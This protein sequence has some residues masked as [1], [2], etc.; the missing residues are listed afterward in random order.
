MIE[1][2]WALPLTLALVGLPAADSQDKDKKRPEAARPA[3]T[4]AEDLLRQAD[5]KAAAGDGAGAVALLRKAQ[6]LPGAPAE[7]GLRLGR[8]LEAARDLDGA[9]D[10]YRE[11]AGK[12]A[13]PAKGEALGRLALVQEVRGLGGAAESAQ[14]AAS[15]DPEGAWPLLALARARAREG[16]GEEAAALAQKAAGKEAGPPAQAA[17]GAAEEARG[18]WA[19]AEAAYRAAGG[20]AS[21]DIAATTGLARVLRRTGRAAEAAPLLEPLIAAYPGAVYAL[22]ESARVKIALGR[23]ADAFADAS[24]AAALADND[25]DAQRVV[26]EATVA[27][28]LAFVAQ[29]QPDLAIQDLTALRD[30]EPNAALV[31]VGLGRALIAKR[32]ADAAV[33]ELTKAAELDPSLAEAHYQLG[34]VHQ[35]LKRDAAA[36]VSAFDKAAAAEPANLDYRTSLGGALVEAKQYDRAVSELAKSTGDPAYR[37]ADAWIY[38]G[39]AHLGARRYKDGIAALEKAAAI[40]PENAQVEAYLAWCYFGLKDASAFKLHGGK[41]RALGHKEPN[42]LQYLTRVEGGEAIK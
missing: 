21:K 36:A 2:L 20:A 5:E 17:L 14:A 13:G 42:L 6:G 22:K 37:K 41:A 25:P 34:Y 10:A 9:V 12:L 33:V 8:A 32:Q 23:A 16:K 28:A 15:A 11:A 24:T 39:A 30:R 3:G 38:L 18:G 26:Q 7:V 29:N 4:S 35:V 27:K 40:A 19:A 31:R 1:H